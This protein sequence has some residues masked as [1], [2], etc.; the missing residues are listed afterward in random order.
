MRESHTLKACKHVITTHDP[1]S[2]SEM[3]QI[4]GRAVRK[5]VHSMLQSNQRN[6]KIHIFTTNVDGILPAANDTTANEGLA[7]HYKILYYKQAN[8]IE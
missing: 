8:K 5:H 1:S 7:Y 2:M 6:V 4:I 3:I